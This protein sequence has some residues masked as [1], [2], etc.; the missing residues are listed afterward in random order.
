MLQDFKNCSNEGSIILRLQYLKSRNFR[1]HVLIK[2]LLC[3][4]YFTILESPVVREI[5]AFVQKHLQKDTKVSGQKPNCT[6]ITE[7]LLS[8]VKAVAQISISS[9]IITMTV[10][11]Y[12]VC[13]SRIGFCSEG[14]VTLD[15]SASQAAVV[16]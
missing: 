5:S 7:F 15:P 8:P 14:E 2:C 3:Y 9:A 16:E 6:A 1:L 10:E 4:P 11:H 13:N 12:A